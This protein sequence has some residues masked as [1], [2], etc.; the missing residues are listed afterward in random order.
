MLEEKANVG[1]FIARK[2][3]FSKRRLSI[4]TTTTIQVYCVVLLASGVALH[5]IAKNSSVPSFGSS[6]TGNRLLVQYALTNEI[7]ILSCYV[8]DPL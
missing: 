7:G 1:N 2:N 4:A 8:V 5:E 3:C 6:E